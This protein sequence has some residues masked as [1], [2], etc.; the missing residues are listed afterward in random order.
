MTRGP[1]A[2][3]RRRCGREPEEGSGRS[4]QRLCV[5]LAAEARARRGAGRREE[6]ADG[7]RATAA[8]CLVRERFERSEEE[9]GKV[10]EGYHCLFL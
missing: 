5:A 7:S 3:P 9:E 4:P 2:Q 8:G 1:Q 6:E 10:C